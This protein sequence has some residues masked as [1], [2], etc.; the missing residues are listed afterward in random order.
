ML[1]SM[2]RVFRLSLYFA[3][4]IIINIVMLTAQ[5]NYIRFEQISPQQGLPQSTIHAILQDSR[6]FMWF[7]TQNGLS[8]F[9]GYKFTEFKYNPKSSSSLPVNK[10]LVIYEDHTGVLWVGTDGGGL[11]R[12]NREQEN[13]TRFRYTNSSDPDPGREVDIIRVIHQDRQGLLW[14]GTLGGLLRF[15]PSKGEWHR[16]SQ[17]SDPWNLSSNNI[18]SIYQD[19]EGVM[20]IATEGGGLNAF[21]PDTKVFKHYLHHPGKPDSLGHNTVT[22]VLEDRSGRLWVGTSGGLDLFDRKSERFIHYRQRAEDEGSLSHDLV[23]IIFEDSR[24]NLWVGTRGGGLNRLASPGK[25]HFFH[26]HSETNNPYSLSHN[27]VLSM[28]EDRAG[29]LWIGTNGGGINRI[30]RRKQKFGHI[31]GAPN[32]PNSLSSNDISAIC[33]DRSGILWVGTFDNGLNRYDRSQR[34][35][36]RF[37]HDS[38]SP[39]SLSSNEVFAIYEDKEGNLWIGTGGGGINRYDQKNG[40]FSRYL[41][42]PGSFAGPGSNVI[43]CFSEDQDNQLWIGTWGGGLNRLDRKKK[44][45]IYYRQDH[46]KLGSISSNHVTT[47]C[48]DLLN[49]AILWVGTYNNGLECFDRTKGTFQHHAHDRENSNSISHN[50]VYVIYISPRDPA[51]VW[52]GTSAGGLNRFDQKTKTWRAFTEE[53]GLANNSVY[54]ILEDGKGHL[55][56]STNQGL[57]RFDPDTDIFTN[58]DASDGLQSN[59]F[60]KG[61]CFKGKDG[62]FYF[63]GI[64]GYNQFYPEEITPNLYP[65]PV[66]FTAFKLS[67]EEVKLEKSILETREVH[68]DYKDYVISFEFAAL[69]YTATAKNRYAYKLEGTDDDWVQLGHKRDITFIRLNPGEYLLRVKGSNNDGVWNEEG[70]SLKVIITPPF[71]NTLWF[72]VLGILLLMAAILGLYKFRVRQYKMQRKRLEKEVAVRTREIREQKEIIEEK[73]KQLEISNRDLKKSEENLIELNATKD[74]FFS[75]ISHDLRNHLTTLLGTSDLLNNA[76]DQ[77]APEKKLKYTRAID[78]SANQLYELLDN[79]LQW[80]RSQ[81]DGLTCK[82]KKIDLNDLLPETLSFYKINARKKKITLS[83]TVPKNSY[84]YAD[85]NMLTSVLRNLISNA[86]KFTDREGEVL[87]AVDEENEE[88]VRISVIDTGVGISDENADALF[89]I[90]MTHSTRGTANEK[91]TGLGLILCKEFIEKNNGRIWYE[92]PGP[93]SEIRGE[94][95]KNGSGSIFR[96]TLPRAKRRI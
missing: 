32:N 55:W 36:T 14:L 80:A 42:T 89:L 54:G 83:S 50:S 8:R 44:E 60:S 65:P 69:N 87:V 18:Q 31:L 38:G 75:I 3:L 41:H 24:G 94:V 79:L 15:D 68:L 47:I 45:F 29:S 76:Y 51:V 52:T 28:A 86:I 58:Y 59:E 33:R 82:P 39:T 23:T 37:L 90:G 84:V 27:M 64:N 81:T 11:N 6:G 61:A 17:W 35:V 9:D 13:F 2:R 12:F 56:I 95:G 48:P 72:K 49:Q 67:N 5:E 53:D 78:R 92:K 74:K 91:G 96:F 34:K 25:V 16:Y 21:E 66:V 4:F 88:N 30:D 1:E 20:W 77:L 71:W 19:R 73:H 43:F 22:A 93:G 85:K 26:F 7:G 57:S 46:S 70:A 63:G 62:R 10:V 40:T